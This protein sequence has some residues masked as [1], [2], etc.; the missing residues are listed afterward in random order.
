VCAK[1]P[2]TLKV[3]LNGG[4]IRTLSLDGSGLRTISFEQLVSGEDNKLGFANA[5]VEE[6]TFTIDNVCVVP[7]TVDDDKLVS[8]CKNGSFEDGLLLPAVN[9]VSPLGTTTL[10]NW[11]GS[12]EAQAYVYGW[13]AEGYPG[14]TE[15]EFA[16]ALDPQAYVQQSLSAGALTI[17]RGVTGTYYAVTFDCAAKDVGKEQR[18]KACR[19]G[20]SGAE[21]TL[22]DVRTATNRSWSTTS[23]LVFFP[24]GSNTVRIANASASGQVLVDNFSCRPAVTPA[25]ERLSNGEFE[26]GLGLPNVAGSS[27]VAPDGAYEPSVWKLTGRGGVFGDDCPRMGGAGTRNGTYACF[28]H[29]GAHLE[30]D[31]T[32][33]VPGEFRVSFA[34]AERMTASADCHAEFTVSVDGEV[35]RAFA[36]NSSSTYDATVFFLTLDSGSHK[37]AFDV[38][39]MGEQA[40]LL[41]SVSV[42]PRNT[43][44]R[45][46][47]VTGH[48]PVVRIMPDT[49]TA[50]L[51]TL[52]VEPVSKDEANV[53][54]DD[55]ANDGATD[56]FR[57]EP[58]AKAYPHPA[59]KAESE[60]VCE[61]GMTFAIAGIPQGVPGVVA[62]FVMRSHEDDRLHLLAL[63]TGSDRKS[64][65][66][67]YYK[68]DD[69]KRILASTNVLTASVGENVQTSRVVS[70][71][72]VWG[73][74]RLSF[75]VNGRA[76]DTV[77][78]PMNETFDF[79]GLCLGALPEGAEGDDLPSR[80]CARFNMSDVRVY[81]CGLTSDEVALLS[82]NARGEVVDIT[83][84]DEATGREYGTEQRRV[85]AVY[86][87]L[88]AI[89][90][91]RDGYAFVGW[92]IGAPGGDCI[93]SD[94][95]VRE[96]TDHRLYANW[97]NLVYRVTYDFNGYPFAENVTD[98][99][100]VGEHFALPSGF[101][102]SGVAFYGWKNA[103]GEYVQAGATF[104]SL[105]KCSDETLTADFEP[106]YGPLTLEFQNGEAP[107][108]VPD[109]EVGSYL[110]DALPATPQREGYTFVGYFSSDVGGTPMTSETRFTNIDGETWYAQWLG[111]EQIVKWRAE[112][113]ALD[114]LTTV[115]RSGEGFVFP[116]SIPSPTNGAERVRFYGWA[117]LTN[118][119]ATKELL[120]VRRLLA[121][122]PVQ[123]NAYAVIARYDWNIGELLVNFDFATLPRDQ[124]VVAL[125][126]TA[127]DLDCG[128][129]HCAQDLTYLYPGERYDA[130]GKLPTPSCEG[131][132]FAGW[133]VG[134]AEGEQVWD[135]SIVGDPAPTNLVASW[136]PKTV[137]VNLDA[138]GGTPY[139][140]FAGD[141]TNVYDAVT[142][143][144]QNPYGTFPT[145]TRTGYALK[146]WRHGNETGSRITP[147]TIVENYEDHTAVAVWTNA[148]FKMTYVI[149]GQTLTG[150]DFLQCYENPWPALYVPTEADLQA[151]G[152]E[153]NSA[154]F[155]G[156][157]LM[158]TQETV[159]EGD[160]A[161]MT[162]NGVLV[163]LIAGAKCTFT[164]HANDGFV[165][166]DEAEIELEY[167]D[168]VPE[169]PVPKRKDCIFVGWFTPNGDE[170]KA[171]DTWVI[172]GTTE[173]I[174]R[175]R[176]AYEK[177]LTFKMNYTVGPSDCYEKKCCYQDSMPQPEPLPS[178]E[179]ARF[180]GWWVSDVQYYGADN[181]PLAGNEKSPFLDDVTL[182]AHW[183]VDRD[184][185]AKAMSLENEVASEAIGFQGTDEAGEPEHDGEGVL[186]ATHWYRF[187]GAAGTE[188]TFTFEDLSG[189]DPFVA[190]AVYD[191]KSLAGLVKKASALEFESA[192]AILAWTPEADG[193]YYLAVAQDGAADGTGLAAYRLTATG[194]GEA[195]P[196]PSAWT[197]PSTMPG[198]TEEE[199]NE[200]A[201]RKDGFP[202]EVARRISSP[203]AYKD[204]T[205]W[206]AVGDP[207]KEIPPSLLKDESAVIL[208]AAFNMTMAPTGEI[209]VA[210]CETVT[211]AV[212]ELSMRMTLKVK[213]DFTVGGANSEALLI[214]AIGVTGS[215]TLD[216]PFTTDTLDYTV[217]AADKA[218]CEVSV[219][220]TPRKEA[221]E[222]P[223]AFF[224]K[225]KAY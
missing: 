197:D 43:S 203:A 84:L 137:R 160:T 1:K 89:A 184:A 119:P 76:Y 10:N 96:L 75:Y 72:F 208:A 112:N 78:F 213:G 216:G 34:F 69:N 114:G 132:A 174:A 144:Y 156:W 33:F 35:V 26:Y 100:V 134:S 194:V 223:S 171:G 117:C 159:K 183:E 60:I 52:G 135:D 71:V 158:E 138:N 165:D 49:A 152:C 19:Q 127:C 101:E 140:E 187:T 31:F 142:V 161:R 188:A 123:T 113:C 155:R 41:D 68:L 168:E 40:L 200:A 102:V 47:D 193:I 215:K 3:F 61:N 63:A 191:G 151:A 172:S 12:G 92:S 186:R 54:Y 202:D 211:N 204:F 9:G 175:W 81:D 181:K 185:F 124:E 170:V 190:L 87:P 206:A 199:R 221:D 65:D 129:G 179:G 128:E 103:Q 126:W 28:L 169:L 133:R 16:L 109:V 6:T 207:E 212:G 27:Y 15:G 30:Q 53:V 57:L 153:A 209:A 2:A 56:F 62:S 91:F 82:S 105:E 99:M 162:K 85:G 217:K 116:E 219:V 14:V 196:P 150:R 51:N 139:T 73:D 178:R 182:V 66:L 210:V 77:T 29:G 192:T 136:A 8:V 38:T 88:A 143:L 122:A 225:G 115:S 67:R 146:E 141:R 58:F 220:V 180:L 154:E 80:S 45:Y 98:E 108:T 164:L 24:E 37:I 79:Q 4:E 59:Y 189:R 120:S 23:V 118:P 42:R 163:A 36:A 147:E 22:A 111:N 17:V 214:A 46:Q 131:Y 106:G 130:W 21:E 39:A 121:D 198:D 64:L 32:V 74:E 218:K 55:F 224:V 97:S 25:G 90:P 201:L 83:L 48:D 104:P 50:T 95:V 125:W 222:H 93:A 195:P 157:M 86:G 7:P 177:T 176:G 18:L 167:G 148:W 5:S 149:N 94:T 173:L 110:K 166:P 20:E 13:A 70:A 145:P 44:I 205:K 11:T 107:V